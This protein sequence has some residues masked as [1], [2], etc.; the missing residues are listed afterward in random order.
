MP[1]EVYV[2]SYEFIDNHNYDS[3]DNLRLA[4][5]SL[6]QSTLRIGLLNPREFTRVHDKSQTRVR[7]NK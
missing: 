3:R 5:A 7:I 6:E 4:L 2:A 1:R